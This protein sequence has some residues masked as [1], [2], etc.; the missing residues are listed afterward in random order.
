MNRP[1][2]LKKMHWMDSQK[3]AEIIENSIPRFAIG[4]FGGWGT[5]KTSLMQMTKKTG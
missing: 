5:G 4:V 3:L 1:K 2:K